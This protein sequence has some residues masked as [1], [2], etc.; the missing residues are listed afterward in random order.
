MDKHK[1][2]ATKKLSLFSNAK[3]FGKHVIVTGDKIYAVKSAK[4]ASRLFDEVVKEN[5]TI[6]MVTYVP[7]GQALIL[8]WR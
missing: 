7:K 5:G 8:L 4:E 1:F 6:P 3:Y 2:S